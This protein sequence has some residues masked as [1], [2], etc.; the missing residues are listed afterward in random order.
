MKLAVLFKI[1]IKIKNE[2]IWKTLHRIL[3]ICVFASLKKFSKDGCIN[4][5][6]N[7]FFFLL[8]ERKLD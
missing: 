7:I 2:V 5:E 3:I 1:M 8:D 6:I 4:Q